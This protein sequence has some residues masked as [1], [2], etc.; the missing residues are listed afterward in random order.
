MYSI[1]LQLCSGLCYIHILL[2]VIN[3]FLFNDRLFNP[4]VIRSECV[5]YDPVYVRS[6]HCLNNELF[7]QQENSEAVGL[8]TSEQVSGLWISYSLLLQHNNTP[9]MTT[10]H[11]NTYTP[12][13]AQMNSNTFMIHTMRALAVKIMTVSVSN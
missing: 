12:T 2:N 13:G 9:A 3:I 10:P 4:P 11:F 8:Q 1:S 6:S 7:K 5:C